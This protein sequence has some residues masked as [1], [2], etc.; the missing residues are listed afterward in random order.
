[1][2]LYIQ[3]I[4]LHIVMEKQSS[5]PVLVSVHITLQ[6]AFNDAVKFVSYIKLLARCICLNVNVAIAS[7][8]YSMHGVYRS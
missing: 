2:S 8:I 7:Y 3:I 5:Q 1:M 4:S 6:C